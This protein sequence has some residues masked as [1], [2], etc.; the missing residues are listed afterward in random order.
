PAIAGAGMIKGLIAG[1]VALEVISE[2][3][4]TIKVLD[5]LASGVFTF[6]PFF[7]AASAAKIFKT[8]TYLAI[9]IAAS[10]MFPTMTEAADAGNV[11]AFH[12]FGFI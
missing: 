8:N 12:L 5:M 9:A 2:K 7:I 6:L 10:M 11:S 4:D 1:L 3:S